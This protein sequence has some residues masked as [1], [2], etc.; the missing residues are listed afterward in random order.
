MR[1]LLVLLFSALCCRAAVIERC[2]TEQEY[3]ALTK[4][5]PGELKIRT[6]LE[7]YN[8]QRRLI[9][10]ERQI[11][12]MHELKY[13]HG[14]EEDAKRIKT[15]EDLKHS[16]N[17]R[18]AQYYTDESQRIWYDWSRNAPTSFDYNNFQDYFHPL[19]TA[20]IFC[21]LTT[22]CNRPIQIW[23]KTSQ[24][25]I[26]NTIILGYRGTFSA[27]DLKRNPPGSQCSRGKNDKGLCIAPPRSEMETSANE[28][29]FCLSSLITCLS[30]ILITF[31]L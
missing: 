17:F 13:D 7:W 30:A 23:A 5:K 28:N 6:N 29:I 9:A 11:A 31:H 4:P 18:L 25:P 1:A 16:H 26:N 10:E 24:M 14:L 21:N 20:F 22:E 27:S 15:C 2:L 19:Q 8:E 3:L 12:N